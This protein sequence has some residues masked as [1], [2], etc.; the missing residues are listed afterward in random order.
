MF[1]T[2]NNVTNHADFAERTLGIS[3]Q[4]FHA[5]LFKP[6][7]PKNVGA[8]PI[9]RCAELLGTNAEYLLC[10]HDDPR[11]EMALEMR[12]FELL[13]SFRV[14]GETDQDALLKTIAA[15]VGR[16]EAAPSVAAPFRAKHPADAPE[17]AQAAGR[18]K[19]RDK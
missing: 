1:M 5:W 4:T 12:E 9:L 2:A 16:A 14:L 11:P 7:N 17:E 6:I 10:V 18:N 15:W 8:V 13:Q 3:R 19:G